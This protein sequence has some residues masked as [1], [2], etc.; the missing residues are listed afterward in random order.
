MQR[1]GERNVSTDE[2]FF[3]A[4]RLCVSARVTL[5]IRS[6]Y[7]GCFRAETLSRGGNAR[8]NFSI[9][10]LRRSLPA[11]ADGS[12]R[13]I[14]FQAVDRANDPIPHQCGSKVE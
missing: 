2:H 14:L 13:V 10:A 6:P 5:P 4:L 12:A 1:R 8:R 11:V 9:L 7:A 3:F